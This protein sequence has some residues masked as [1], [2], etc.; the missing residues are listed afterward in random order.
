MYD[1]IIK[2][3]ITHCIDNMFSVLSNILRIV[4]LLRAI[5][6]GYSYSLHKYIPMVPR[7]EIIIMSEIIVD[8]IYNNITYNFVL[9]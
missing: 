9:F 4:T 1:I 6:V 2:Y 5:Y 7:V 8:I 3:A